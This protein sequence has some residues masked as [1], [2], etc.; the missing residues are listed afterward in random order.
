M[1]AYKIIT[2][3]TLLLMGAAAQAATTPKIPNDKTT[4][5]LFVK[6]DIV[7]I[8]QFKVNG[9]D[10]VQAD[11]SPTG[12]FGE[13]GI[14]HK[15][16]K[17]EVARA[18]IKVKDANKFLIFMELKDKKGNAYKYTIRP[19]RSTVFV[20][21]NP[22]KPMAL[23]PQTGPLKGWLGKTESGLPLKNNLK[24][25]NIVADDTRSTTEKVAGAFSRS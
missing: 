6:D 21:F 9:G 5:E 7:E 10:I 3:L 4:F 20:T 16:R 15:K 22:E 25:E 19:A 2:G 13:V 17:G 14:L 1:N 12:V 11:F 24:V 18:E 23:Y 8:A